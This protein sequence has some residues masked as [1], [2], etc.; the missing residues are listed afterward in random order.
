VIVISICFS[1]FFFSFECLFYFSSLWKGIKD[2]MSDSDGSKTFRTQSNTIRSFSLSWLERWWD[3][4]RMG[5][6]LC[7]FA[8]P[9]SSSQVPIVFRGR[10]RVL[11]SVV[12]KTLVSWASGNGVDTDRGCTFLQSLPRLFTQP[13]NAAS[14]IQL[15][16]WFRK[17]WSSN[18]PFNSIYWYSLWKEYP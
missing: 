15:K 16:K 3:P 13:N 14:F 18:Q 17:G 4:K 5:V 1:A 9:E 10:P 7:R 12:A 2:E 6:K 11:R 8:A